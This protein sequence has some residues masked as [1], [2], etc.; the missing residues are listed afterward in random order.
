[1]KMNYVVLCLA[2]VLGIAIAA[3]IVALSN[4]SISPVAVKPGTFGP[5]A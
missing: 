3:P 4:Y 2:L 5:L 1:M